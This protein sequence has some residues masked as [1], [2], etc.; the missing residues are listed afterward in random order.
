MKG[1]VFTELLA[2]M[3]KEFG[4]SV[5]EEVLA[6]ANLASGGA[7][8]TV[9]TYDHTEAVSIVMALSRIS[10]VPAADLLKAFG[11]YLL[12][13]FT[14]HYPHFFADKTELF[15][16]LEGVH[17][18]IHVEVGKLY[19]DATLPKIF[20]KRLSDRELQLDYASCRQM[21]DVAEGLLNGAIAHFGKG[22][23][24]VRGTTTYKGE[25]QWVS[26]ILKS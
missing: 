21:G 10:G 16:F 5:T 11:A 14:V 7:Y 26:F 12:G 13:R 25:E 3:D 1:L 2:M 19:P 24:L 9:G 17:D 15:E 8:T 22:H 20:T 18:Y 23:T 4:P 6:S